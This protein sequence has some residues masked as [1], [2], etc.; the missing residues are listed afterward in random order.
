MSAPILRETVDGRDLRVAVVVSRFN[1]AVTG[2]LLAGA[3]DALDEAGVPEAAQTICSVPGAIEIPVVAQALAKS[4]RVDAVA[5]IGAVIR[6]ETSHY[7]HVCRVAA[8]GCARVSLDTGVPVALGV[9]TCDTEEQALA[10]SGDGASNKGYEAV[11]VAVEMARL[12]R[13]LR[14]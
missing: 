6:G 9:L 14:A 11:M 4:G 13:R 3:R 5:A 1:E 7:D 10:R 12:L 2:R 8:D